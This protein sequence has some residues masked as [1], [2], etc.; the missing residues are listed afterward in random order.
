MFKKLL[1]L[2]LPAAVFMNTTHAQVKKKITKGRR[3][4]SQSQFELNEGDLE[5][6]WETGYETINSQLSNAV[7]PNAVVHYGIS[8]RFEVNTE[9]SVVTAIDKSVSPQKNTSGIE[10]VLIGANYQIIEDTGYIPSVII[11]TQLGIPF[12]ATKNF[13]ADHLAPLVQVNIQES[14]HDKFI[15]S[16]N[17]GITWDG[18]SPKPQFIYDESIAY[19]LMK[20]WQFTGEFSGFVS[21]QPVQNNLDGSIAY[22][23]N[24]YTQFGITAGFGISPAAHKSY[25]AINGTWGLNTKRRK[26]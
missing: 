23:L 16:L 22:V 6:E 12:L 20:K 1:L 8:N 4:Q 14:I 11:A 7:Y 26:H 24:D 2:L 13:T 5:I 18:F 10:P 19:T 25:F 21:N 9:M 15:I 17:N 3:N